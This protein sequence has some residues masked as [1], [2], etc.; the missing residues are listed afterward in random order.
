VSYEVTL[1]PTARKELLR[2]PKEV[3]ARIM[4]HLEGLDA[5]PYPENSRRLL[6]EYRGL[7]RLRVGPYRVAY[8][9]DEQAQEITIVKIGH[10]GRFYQS[11]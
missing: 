2:L 9:V 8:Q 11:L 3:Q 10:R 7:V 5:E 1:L 6:G 4:P